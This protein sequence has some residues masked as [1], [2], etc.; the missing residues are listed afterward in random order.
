MIKWINLFKDAFMVYDELKDSGWRISKTMATS[1]IMILSSIIVLTGI[2]DTGF[3]DAE[4]MAI[5]TGI[6]SSVIAIIRVFSDGGRIKL[7]DDL[8]PPPNARSDDD[9]HSQL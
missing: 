4:I 8:K 6:Y 3:T 7:H 5:G 9:E 2:V 1:T